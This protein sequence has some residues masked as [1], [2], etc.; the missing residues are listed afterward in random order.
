MYAPEP[1][2]SPKRLAAIAGVVLVH[3]ALIIGLKNGLSRHVMD[4]IREPLDVKIIEEEITIDKAPPPPPVNI[5]VP[6][7]F[8]PPPEVQI[9]LPPPPVSTAIQAVTNTQPV[10]QPPTPLPPGPPKYTKVVRAK[11]GR[12][13]NSDDF[14]PPSAKRMGREGITTVRVCVGPNGRLSEVPAVTESSGDKTLDEGAVK[15]AQAGRYVAGTND[16]V[17]TTD[18]FPFRIKFE[19]KN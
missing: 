4:L 1:S 15:Y 3:V 11:I 14:Y 7:P 17:P 9:N 12:F 18:C 16:G 2:L 10:I 19:L 6:P 8:V 13:P 5:D